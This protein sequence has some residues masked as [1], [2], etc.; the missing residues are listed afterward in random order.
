MK[1]KLRGLVALACAVLA[2]LAVA[3]PARAEG[4]HT[5]T[6]RSETPG[7]NYVAYQVFAGDV[8]PDGVTLSN[9]SWGADVRGDALLAA[10]KA[11]G[12]FG[13]SNPFESCESAADVAAVLS[14]DGFTATQA[15]AFAE[16]A[17]DNV[18]G[19]P[20]GFGFE[21]QEGGAYVYMATG[22]AAGYYLVQD[23][24]GSPTDLAYAK[25][26]FILQVVADV[27]VDA[28]ADHPT[29]TK[30]IVENGVELAATDAAIGDEV[31]FKLTS[32]VPEMDGYNRYHFVVTD[33]LSAGFA[34]AKGFGVDDVTVEVGGT[35]LT[36]DY[37]V[38]TA[39]EPGGGTTITITLSDLLS[40]KSEDKSEAG[41]TLTIEYA[42]T[43]DDDAVIGGAGNANSATLRF[44]ND[45][46]HTY[47]QSVDADA[48]HLGQT[49]PSVTR[50]YVGG[51]IIHKVN[52][53]D[54]PLVGARFA[55][56]G[57]ELNRVILVGAE[58]VEDDGGAYY[59]LKS[60]TYTTVA[61]TD[62]TSSSYVDDMT[63]KLSSTTTTVGASGEPKSVTSWVNAE[64]DIVV[65]GLSA[66]AYTVTELV[67]PDAYN[68]A[69]P[70]TVKLGFVEP[71]SGATACTWTKDGQDVTLE[72]SEGR[73]LVP[74]T[75]ENLRGATLPSTGGM[76][77]TVLVC[78]GVVIAVAAG[79]GLVAKYRA[80]RL[81]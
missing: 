6:V 22:L 19:N 52:E 68:K 31:S 56:T 3:V 49:P 53:I 11:S 42:A 76:G 15:D 73:G 4:G 27:T 46:N 10:L 66:G 75:I 28:K 23:A 29:L 33:T 59:A 74:V 48:D 64:G 5:L 18:E 44:S 45:P 8:S 71:M 70:V 57:D 50:T 39:D 2:A 24:E 32:T 78:V 26:K 25:T 38:T 12:A 37:T 17:G 43:V 7:H 20:I 36:D 16:V 41:N 54:E 14:G 65:A 63:Y 62:E 47:E 1:K 9:V 21:A 60:G 35:T 61:P 58:F 80:D 13:Q 34:L 81:A 67:A 77:K 55:V 72:T 69:D 51:L 40:Y 79:V 30:T